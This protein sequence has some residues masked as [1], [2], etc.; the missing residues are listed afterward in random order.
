M[1]PETSPITKVV[2]CPMEVK[3][4]ADSQ[5]GGLG[6]MTANRGGVEGS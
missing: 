3:D 1:L 5:F 6:P 2:A 4:V